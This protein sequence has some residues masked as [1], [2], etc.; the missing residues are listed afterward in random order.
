VHIANKAHP[1]GGGRT[2]LDLG[3]IFR[4]HGEAFRAHSSLSQQQLRVM[5]SIERCRTA[6]LGG[7]LYACTREDCDFVVPAYNSCRDR[8]C[9]K[10]QGKA[11]FEWIDAR[12]E[13]LLNS[14][15]FHVVFTL[16]SELRTIAYKNPKAIYD[17]LLS[18]AAGT[19]IDL[20]RDEK[21]LG[22]LIGVTAILHT[23][24]RT[25]A[26][27]PHAHC[28]VTGGGLAPE[29]GRWISVTRDF[30]F[31]VKVMG[32][33]FRGKFLAGLKKLNETRAVVVNDEASFSALIDTL[34]KASWVVYAK[35]PFG[36]PSQVFSYLGRYTHRVGI[37]NSRLRS[38]DD[39]EVTFDT[40]NGQTA[41]LAPFEFIRRFLQHVLPPGFVKIRH[42]G[43]HASVH[44]KTK[45]AEAQALL[46]PLP[47]LHPDRVEPQIGDSTPRDDT[48]AILLLLLDGVEVICPRCGRGHLRPIQMP[49]RPDP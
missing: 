24:T 47:D 26:Y 4:T 25:L 15:Y 14:S 34:Y 6:A 46:G 38:I 28:I 48:E 42:Y 31:P 10:C 19:L 1:P 27:H 23:W 22:G 16:P 17:L 41:S 32:A 30:L 45:L 29:G 2:D 37:A 5:Q 20:G 13:R 8:H 35:R 49:R 12:K 40:K 18:S 33:L 39:K 9:P 36:G 11:Q 7:H 3:L 21:R 43:L 44:S